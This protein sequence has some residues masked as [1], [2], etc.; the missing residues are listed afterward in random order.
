M[1]FKIKRISDATSRKFKLRVCHI[2]DTHGSL[3]RLEGRYDLVVHSGDFFPNSYEVMNKNITKEMAFQLDWLSQNLRKIKIWLQGTPMFFIPG[4]HDF[5]H[6]QL[7][8]QT[9]ASD[10]IIATDITEKVHTF[11]GV[12][13]YGFPYVPAING[14]WNYEKEIPEM[15]LEVDKLVKTLNETY[16]DVLVTHAPLYQTL[17]LTHGNETIG[18]TVLS[19]ALDYKIEKNRLPMY[20]LCG[21]CHEAHG[22]SIRGEML[23]SNA[24]CTAHTIEVK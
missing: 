24:A 10:G 18:S 15:E 3:P 20:L 16:V 8:E 6:P 5:L 1:A 12:N 4:N 23:V 7:T 14:M 22:V 2:S 21:H 13:F 11:L 17:D 19:N 9:L